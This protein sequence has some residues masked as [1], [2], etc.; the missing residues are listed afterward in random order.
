MNQASSSFNS[1]RIIRPCSAL[2]L[3]FALSDF[4]KRP[5][6]VLESANLFRPS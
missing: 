6:L 5:C 4:V 3:A 2:A 1:R